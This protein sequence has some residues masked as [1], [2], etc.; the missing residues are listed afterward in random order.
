MVHIIKNVNTKTPNEIQ[1]IFWSFN[2]V[3]LFI[4]CILKQEV[5]FEAIR[6]RA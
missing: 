4:A 3:T 5:L 1:S 6:D 2:Q